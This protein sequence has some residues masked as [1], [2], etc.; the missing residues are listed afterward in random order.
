[1][2]YVACSTNEPVLQSNTNGSAPSIKAMEAESKQTTSEKEKKE[3]RALFVGITLSIVFAANIGGIG[4]LT[5]TGP[6][7]ILK[8]NIDE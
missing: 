7:L 3:L 5:G 2:T 1:M 4:T 6:N 8:K